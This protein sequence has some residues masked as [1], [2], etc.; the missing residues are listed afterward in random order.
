MAIRTK[1]KWTVSAIN[2]LGQ[3]QMVSE[4]DIGMCASEDDR[5]PKGGGLWDSTSVKEGERNIPYK[6]VETSN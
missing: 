3:L 4:Q 1:A 6:G 5:P 2:G